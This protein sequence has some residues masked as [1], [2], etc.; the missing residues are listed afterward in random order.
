MQTDIQYNMQTGTG[1]RDGWNAMA[2]QLATYKQFGKNTD[3]EN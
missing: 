2:A 3:K 1:S